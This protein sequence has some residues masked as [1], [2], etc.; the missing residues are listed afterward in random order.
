MNRNKEKE[1]RR[2]SDREINESVGGMTT[3]L[4]SER[5]LKRRWWR[6][7]HTQLNRQN[8]QCQPRL[9]KMVAM[10]KWLKTF[11]TRF[12]PVGKKKS[13]SNAC[14]ALYTVQVC[15]MTSQST[16]FNM[17]KEQLATMAANVARCWTC[18]EWKEDRHMYKHPQ[19]YQSCEIRGS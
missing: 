19:T 4:D 14:N 10:I 12:F 15:L 1:I 16:Q 8:S 3:T 18:T 7:H 11:E 2:G 5:R 9:M 17:E 13:M 6:P